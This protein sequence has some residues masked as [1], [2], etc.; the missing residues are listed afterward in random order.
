MRDQRYRAMLV[1]H[2]AIVNNPFWLW[3]YQKDI[4]SRRMPDPAG[5]GG[6]ATGKRRN[7]YDE[8]LL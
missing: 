7:L 3:I 6:A 4:L 1:T 2:A 5:I 8:F